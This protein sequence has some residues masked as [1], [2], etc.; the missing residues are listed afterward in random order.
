M[1]RTGIVYDDRY[2]EHLT[3]QGAME[4]PPD[5]GLAHQMSHPEAPERIKNVHSLMTSSGFIDSLIQISPQVVDPSI[6]ELVH[7]RRYID[8]VRE[9]SQSGGGRI[10]PTT[11]LSEKSYEIALLAV[12]GCIAGAEATLRGE[13]KNAYALIRPPGHH[14]SRSQGM[15]FCLFNNVAITA[16]YLKQ[17]CGLKRVLIVDW[18]VHHGNGTQSIFYDDPSVVFFSLHQ[19]GNY[20]PQSGTVEEVGNGNGEGYTINIPL[21]PGTGDGGYVSALREVVEPVCREFRPEF[22]LVSA[23]QDPSMVDPLGRMCL[24]YE[25]FEKMTSIVKGL[26][27]ECCL[28]RL[29]IA[30]EGGYNIVYQPYAVVTIL[31][32]LSGQKADLKKP[33]SDFTYPETACFRDNLQRVVSTQR[34]YWDL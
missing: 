17:Q 21:P 18:D 20:P 23:G 30:Q 9:L 28:G 27:Q 25:G 34:R 31:E 14:A 16:E 5:R 26:A 19:D 22:I 8:T 6:L 15:G 12:G 4:Y 3:G 24:T 32:T 11:P 10:S 13:V 1:E 7:D 2:L 29:L 33:Y